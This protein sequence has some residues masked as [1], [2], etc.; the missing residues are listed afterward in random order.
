RAHYN[1]A[2]K[3]YLEFTFRADGS[4]KFGEN[5]RWGYFPALGAS[6]RVHEEPF[7]QDVSF[8]SNLKLRASYGITGN[9]G[10]IDDFASLGLWAGGDNYA[11][12]TGGAELP[13]TAPLQ[14]ANPDLKWESTAQLS[15]GLDIGLLRDRINIELNYYRKYTSD[16]LLLVA[17]PGTSGFSSYLTNYG[18]ISN[19]GF[20]IAISATNIRSRNFSWHTDF[21]VSQNKNRIEKIPADIPLAGRDL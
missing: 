16:A 20:E 3:Y 9:Q 14:L 4:S 1:Y 18:E 15:T 17:T 7:L 5:N 19:N 11:D 10:G 12:V 8:I 6:W 21:N 13:G 2:N